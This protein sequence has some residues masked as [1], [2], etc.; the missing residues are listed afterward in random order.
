MT[1]A[2]D[3]LAD[4]R[5]PL[6]HLF[7]RPA[8]L[9]LVR[10]AL[11]PSMLRGPFPMPP[12]LVVALPVERALTSDGYVLLLEGVDEGRVVHQLHPLPT[13]EDERQIVLRV[14]AELECRALGDVQVDVALE[15]NRAGQE[16]ARG[17]DDAPA[18]RPVA[19]FDGFTYRPRVVEV[20][21]RTRPVVRDGKVARGELRRADA[22]EYGGN[23]VPA[24]G[25]RRALRSTHRLSRGADVGGRAK[26]LENAR[27]QKKG[28]GAF[29]CAAH[30]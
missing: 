8:C 19:R 24:D 12:V 14:S 5:A 30:V 26:H 15:V 7:K 28:G 22:R 13:R 23:R 1:F 9:L 27:E 29:E 21:A 16:R 6:D 3:A 4:R 10:V 11:L 2:E 17:H 20:A 25:A 18:P